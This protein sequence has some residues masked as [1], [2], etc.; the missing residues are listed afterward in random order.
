MAPGLIDN[1]AGWI[2]PGPVNKNVFPD[3]Y[4]TSGQHA[5]IYSLVQPYENFPKNITGPTAW[6]AE[7]FKNNPEK[8]THSFTADEVAE[9]DAAAQ[10]FIDADYPLTGMTKVGNISSFHCR[11]SMI[12]TPLSQ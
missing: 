6:K 8:W 11:V 4:K 1:D 5:P 9:I 7:D 2:Q 12:F 3:G 10:A